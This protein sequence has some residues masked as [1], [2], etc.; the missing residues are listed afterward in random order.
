M[1]NERRK[2]PGG[3]PRLR[4][5]QVGWALTG[6]TIPLVVA[7]FAWALLLRVPVPQASVI[8]GQ[9]R[10]L[11]D[12]VSLAIPA[13]MSVEKVLVGEGDII[14]EGRALIRLDRELGQNVLAD[15]EKEA[16]RLR[17][18]RQCALAWPLDPF[19]GRRQGPV[20]VENA[21]DPDDWDRLAAQVVAA[22][23]LRRA[24]VAASLIRVS[25][26][27]ANL[28]RRL[29]LLE[30]KVQ[31]ARRNTRAGGVGENAYEAL[32]LALAHNLLSAE[33]LEARAQVHQTRLDAKAKLLKDSQDALV[34]LEKLRS[35][36]AELRHQLSDPVIRAPFDGIVRRVRVG[37]HE[38]GM[39][40]PL[41]AIELF[42]KSG[43]YMVEAGMPAER[44]TRLGKDQTARVVVSVPG[45]PDVILNA[46]AVGVSPNGTAPRNQD[47][48]TSD[49]LIVQV[50]FLLDDAS[51][52]ALAA[53]ATGLAIHG[54]NTVARVKLTLAPTPVAGRIAASLQRGLKTGPASLGA[55]SGSTEDD[56][57]VS[58]LNGQQGWDRLTARQDPQPSPWMAQAAPISAPALL[59]SPP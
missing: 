56:A 20:S 32:S 47:P 2:K 18:L 26:I 33:L 7:V 51:R 40:S 50:P 9:L 12:P 53:G 48:R 54:R 31:L 11:S 42:P 43:A 13:R 6:V 17:L 58:R 23:D 52:D 28:S 36:I 27:E 15:L 29:Q 24:E 49:G 34:T 4:A 30:R 45:T 3:Q 1:A 59:P 5:R 38:G 57:S 39:L 21:E 35:V 19:S 22:C 37:P 25:A 46:T 14:H 10:P 41:P 55:G 8:D 44:A 16:R